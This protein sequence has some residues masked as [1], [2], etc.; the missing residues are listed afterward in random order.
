MDSTTTND[1][2]KI[3]NGVNNLIT[4]IKHIPTGYYNITKN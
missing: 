1:F 3:T 4:I 2:E